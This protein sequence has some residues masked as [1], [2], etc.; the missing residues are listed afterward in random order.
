MLLL[1]LPLLLLLYLQHPLVHPK[2][3]LG[4]VGIRHVHVQRRCVLSL[5]A[6]IRS[7]PPW[8][9]DIDNCFYCCVV[10]I[11]FLLSMSLDASHSV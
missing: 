4:N 8:W 9:I 5:V 3:G 2:F 11:L 1:L 7:D 10:D 6:L